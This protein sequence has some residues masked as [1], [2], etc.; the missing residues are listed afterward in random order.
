MKFKL[1]LRRVRVALSAFLVCMGLFALPEAKAGVPYPNELYL[2]Q[3]S[4]VTCTLVSNAMM[5]RARTY[6]SNNTNWT[7]ITEASLE[8]FGWIN[9]AGQRSRYSATFGNCSYTVNQAYVNGL[10]IDQLQSILAAHPEGVCIYVTSIPHAQWVTDIENGVVYSG[11]SSCAAYFGRRPLANTYQGQ[12][13]GYNQYTVLSNVT[14]YWYV[15]SYNV[16]ANTN[17][18]KTSITQERQNLPNGTYRI[19]C[20]NNINYGLDIAGASTAD[21]ANVQVWEYGGGDQQK[22]N[23]TFSG[24]HYN[25]QAVHSGKNLDLHKAGSTSGTNVQQYYIDGTDVQNW[26]LQDAGDGAYYIINNNGLYMDVKDGTVANSTN[27]QGHEGN[28]SGAQKWFFIAVNGGQ[29]IPDGTYQIRLAKNFTYGMVESTGASTK[30]SN[31][32]LWTVGN[33]DHHKWNVKYLGNGYYSIRLKLGEMALNV[34]DAAYKGYANIQQYPYTDGDVASMWLLKEAGNGSFYIVNKNGLFVDVLDGK[35]TNGTNIGGWCGNSSDAQKWKFVAVDGTQT[36]ADGYYTI[37]SAKDNNFGLDVAERSKENSANV[38]LWTISTSNNNNQKWYVKSLGNG[39]YSMTAAHS[40][41]ALDMQNAGIDNYCNVQQY[42]NSADSNDAQQWLLKDAGNGAYYIVHKNG[43]FLDI[44]NGTLANGTNIRGHVGNC[45]DAQKWIF[46]PVDIDQEP[47][48]ITDIKITNISHAGYTVTCTVTDNEKVS[49]VSMPTWSVANDQD[50]IQWYVATLDG[51]TA[52]C[53]INTANHNNESGVYLT[54]IYA[55]DDLGN[56]TGVSAGEIEVPLESNNPDRL[57]NGTYR[58]AC[59]SNINYGLDVADASTADE[60]NVMIYE[61]NGG[62]NQQFNVTYN[63]GY[64]N[65]QA[66]HSGK[67]IDLYRAGSASGT[68]VQQYYV[69]GTDVQNWKLQA[70]GDGTYFIVNS[71]GLYMDVTDGLVANGT[72]VQGHSGNQS[73]AQ[74]WVFI[75]VNGAQTIPDGDYQIRL[76]KDFRY[77][78]GVQG[79]STENG[80][81]VQLQRI[82]GAE[83]QK[84]T[85]KYLGDGYYSIRAKHSDMALNLDGMAYKGNPNVQQ[86]PFEDGDDAS[87]WIIKDS[88]DGNFYI[89][90]KCGRFLDVLDGNFIDGTNIGGWTGNSSDAQKFKFVAVDGSQ[91]IEDGVY[92]IRNSS[93]RDYVLDVDLA[94]MDNSANVQLCTRNGGDNQKWRVSYLGDGYYSIVAVHSDKALDM[95]NAGTENHCNV[96]QY[97]NTATTNVAQQWII[98]EVADKEF[99]IIH[100]NGLFLDIANGSITNGANIQGFMGNGSAAQKWVFTDINTGEPSGVDT[101]ATAKTIAKVEYY[102]VSGQVSETPFDGFNLI[103]TI[104]DDGT[105][106]VKKAFVK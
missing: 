75:A 101:P 58:I 32:H 65:L 54:H 9:G 21:E 64:Y 52:T 35:I 28:K 82:N 70:T 17:Y 97:D 71:N 39:Y 92:E 99:Y 34:S 22:F 105:K 53:T 33:V 24:D 104:Y 91:S 45:S 4:D 96:Q 3:Q 73:N 49:S 88:G 81:S 62:T 59:Y 13:C 68:N 61:Y 51:N 26:V 20:Y 10:T 12:C 98:R 55:Y 15:E 23:V 87:V 63:N 103:V 85:V 14:S 69:D 40:R 89:I 57:P 25:I 72:N 36:I 77:G 95:Q 60:A 43:L 29:S 93:N 100:K 47:P 6:L 8:P 30:N 31:I 2:T 27:V 7:A 44:E 41:K 16:P 5:L 80:A 11:D 37:R 90:N 1:N 67:N 76:S 42:D 74:K 102:N 38:H 46:T 79:A 66:V 56:M 19:A 50:D 106:E 86:H 94:S 83:N 84:W 78:A 18:T 48:V